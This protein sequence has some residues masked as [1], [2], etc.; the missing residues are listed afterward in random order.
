MNTTESKIETSSV[1]EINQLKSVVRDLTIKTTLLDWQKSIDVTDSL[2]S[3]HCD[4]ELNYKF[5][6]MKKTLSENQKKLNLLQSTN[7]NK[8]TTYVASLYKK[9]DELS[10]YFP[11]VTISE[12]DI[13]GELQTT[14][15][16]H[17]KNILKESTS[18]FTF[19]NWCTQ[20][21]ITFTVNCFGSVPDIKM[22]KRIIGAEKLNL[23]QMITNNKLTK[24]IASISQE[25][26]VSFYPIINITEVYLSDEEI[27]IL[28]DK[29]INNVVKTT[30][31]RYNS[32]PFQSQQSNNNPFISSQTTEHSAKNLFVSS[33]ITEHSAK[34][35]FVSS[36]ITEHSAKNPF[37]SSQTTEH[38]AK[39]LFVS[40]QITEHSAKNPFVSSQTTE[41]SA[42]NPFVSSQT[43]EHSAKNPFVS[44]Q[45]TEHSAKN[46][47]VSSQITEHSDIN[48]FGIPSQ[49]IEKS[50]NKQH[51]S[52]PFS[53]SQ[54]TD[55]SAINSLKTLPQTTKQY[56][57]NTK[58]KV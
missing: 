34:N 11:F 28:I 24:F 20:K 29:N 8:L 26:L 48:P 41:H 53:F 49:T 40:S 39:N 2:N 50:T 31:K 23:L 51:C 14:E 10:T 17:F 58:R 21:N 35:L 33:Q 12:V 56:E 36:Q 30:N 38:S 4:I 44:S 32:N 15:L 16:D 25:P 27:K 22:G 13:I 54:T 45:I 42:K 5:E 1:D 6:Q 57:R 7:N 46:P 47:F 19:R 37:V 3:W 52:N 18:I 9:I 55:R 43:T